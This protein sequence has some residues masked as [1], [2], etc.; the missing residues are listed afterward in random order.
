M[1]PFLEQT[2]YAMAPQTGNEGF[3]GMLSG[4]VPLILV[5]AIFWFLVIRPQQKRAKEHRTLVANIKKGDEVYTDSGILGTIQ[6][7]A[8]NTVTL[9]IAPK[10]SVRVQRS[11]ISD[12]VKESKVKE[13][14]DREDES[15]SDTSN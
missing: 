8:E 9:E 4:F 5:F 1:W 12:L 15:T 7:V 14:K 11:R 10:V 3:T 2:A 13:P 6:K